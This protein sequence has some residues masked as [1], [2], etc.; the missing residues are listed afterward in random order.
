MKSYFYKSVLLAGMCAGSASAISLYDMAPS[1]GLPQ[2]HAMQ[3]NAYA[4]LGY[5]SNMN[6]SFGEKEASCYVNAGVGASYADFESVDKISYNVNLG[7]TKYLQKPKDD[8]R[9][10]YAD[11][12][13]SA[14]MVHSFSASSSY[15][16]SLSM[17]YSPEPDYASGVSASRRQGDCLYWSFNNSYHEAMDAR[18]SW[19]VGA[20]YSGNL[21][22]ETEFQYDDR[23]YLSAN[24]GL[25]Y[26]A[27]ELLS[28]NTSLSYRYDFRDKGFNSNNLT[29]SIGFSLALDPV[30]S[31]CGNLGLQT[32]QVDGEVFLSPNLYLGYNRKVSEGLSASAFISL[33]NENVDTYRISGDYLS[34]LALRVGVNSTYT[35]SPAVSFVFGLSAVHNNYSRGTNRMADETSITIEPTV[36]MDYRFSEQLTGNIR[37]AYTW[38]DIDRGS[39]YSEGYTRHN[40]SAG[41]T[42]SF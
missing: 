30:S 37:Y 40:V 8:G 15:M 24:A 21:Y 31:C 38:Y 41:V 42:Y 27:T 13:L 6:T 26:R 36:G 9:T 39:T 20:S 4:R 35:L 12:G 16:A 33:S 19:N 10:M 23:Q 14:S 7:A 25:S 17:T 5:D 1:V 18:W 3:C 29:L 22:S 28:Y 32:K 2:S 34:D 11:C